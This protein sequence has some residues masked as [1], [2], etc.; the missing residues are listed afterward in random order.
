MLAGYDMLPSACRH[1]L[2][3]LASKLRL[4]ERYAQKVADGDWLSEEEQDEIHRVGI[5]LLGLFAD[6]RGVQEKSALLVADVAS[7]SN[8]ERVLHEGTGHMNPLI[9]VYTP[10]GG[11]PVAGIGYVFS[12]YEFVETGWNRLT[13]AEWEVKLQRDPPPRPAWAHG[14]LPMERLHF[15]YLPWVANGLP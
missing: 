11:E 8:T 15:M 7:D 4:W 12:H 14:F 5:W 9:V 2:G 10:P 13:D 3:L 6:G 1:S